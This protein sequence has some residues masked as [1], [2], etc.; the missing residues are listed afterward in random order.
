MTSQIFY[1]IRA[2]ELKEA[3]PDKLRGLKGYRW[4]S[5]ALRDAWAA[6]EG[7]GVARLVVN[8]HGRIISRAGLEWR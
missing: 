4:R 6:V 3:L 7:D 5:N 1:V 8:Q 2:A